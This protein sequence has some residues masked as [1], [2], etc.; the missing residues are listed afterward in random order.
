LRAYPAIL[1]AALLASAPA[2]A[3][4]KTYSI[5]SGL[6]YMGNTTVVSQDGYRAAVLSSFINKDVWE[7]DGVKLAQAPKGTFSRSKSMFTP[8]PAALNADGSLLVHVM[9]TTDSS[10]R[11]G[12]SAA[13][14]GKPIG[15]V[16]SEISLLRVSPRGVNVAYAARDA[17]GW[18]VHSAQ[19]AGP[20]LPDAPA[21]V[22]VSDSE[23]V[24]VTSWRGGL[25]MY[26]NGVPSA[27]RSFISMSATPDLKRIGGVFI[28]P[29]TEEYW[30]DVDGAASG[31]YMKAAAPVFS[32]DGRHY[33]FLAQKKSGQPY[34]TVVVDGAARSVS[35][36]SDLLLVD[37]AG[38]PY[39]TTHSEN[40]NST[41]YRDGSVLTTF[42]GGHINPQWAGF[43]PS[44]AHYALWSPSHLIVDGRI[45][46][47]PAPQPS[48]GMSIVFDGERE[49]HYISDSGGQLVC[50][51]VDGSSAANTRCAAIGRA[52][53]KSPKSAE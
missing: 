8:E 27:A 34:D 51:S 47:D 20:S 38:V 19:G 29:R 14:N 48:T 15:G 52:V 6:G 36:N 32:D 35:P 1:C 44:G 11:T 23:T 21:F 7:K 41:D 46:E 2:R 13:L 43:S 4:M 16:Y 22:F 10:G 39:W 18:S 30:V 31:P 24:Y 9:T 17:S 12:V 3:E 33:A 25:W 53:D 28:D 37:D 5:G 42:Y 45:A 26:R 50:V 40:G 49:F